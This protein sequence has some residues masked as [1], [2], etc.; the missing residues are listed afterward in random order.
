MDRPK[1]STAKAVREMLEANPYIRNG[2]AEGL[3]NFS[4]LARK[5]T[6]E[7]EA[8]L[9]KKLNGDS[10]IVAI[11]RYSDE[12]EGRAIKKDYLHIFA[13]SQLTLQENMAYVI[14]ERTPETTAKIESLLKEA[15]WQIGELRIVVQGAQRIMTLMKNNRIESLVEEAGNRVIEEIK[16]K[17]LVTVHTP[18][19][20]RLTYGVIAEIAAVL[21]KKGITIDLITAHS[22]LHFL[23]QESDAEETYHTMREFIR[24]SKE[25]LETKNT[26]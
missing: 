1:M 5:M 18:P 2:L 25:M 12:I 21:S 7:L 19:E 6:P 14:L 26:G 23:V 13:N 24:K 17:A 10:L 20:S 11:K 16:D 15:D 4:A 3:I 22:D 8:K 9:G